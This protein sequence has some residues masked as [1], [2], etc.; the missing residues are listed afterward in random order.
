[1]Y[2]SF[3]PANSGAW[4]LRWTV[5]GLAI[6]STILASGLA[7]MGVI[8]QTIWLATEPEQTWPDQTTIDRMKAWDMYPVAME[9]WDNED[10]SEPGH[11]PN[12]TLIPYRDYL[13]IIRIKGDIDQR[14][15]AMIVF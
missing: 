7:M 9:I 6:L 1:I 8:H 11:S 13:H 3:D 5:L 4:K 14:T 15:K 12:S 2:G 10:N